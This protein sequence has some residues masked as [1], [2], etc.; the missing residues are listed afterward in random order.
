MAFYDI[1]NK[2]LVF[3]DDTKLTSMKKLMKTFRYKV[4]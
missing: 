2:I 3:I 1:E 4:I